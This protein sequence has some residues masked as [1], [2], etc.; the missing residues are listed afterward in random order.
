MVRPLLAQAIRHPVLLALGVLCLWLAW[1]VGVALLAYALFAERLGWHQPMGLFLSGV[2]DGLR[3][4]A[5]CCGPSVF[6]FSPGICKADQARPA[7]TGTRAAGDTA[8]PTTSFS[9]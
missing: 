5:S 7:G 3:S 1:P 6:F 8:R 4:G 9:P 2:R